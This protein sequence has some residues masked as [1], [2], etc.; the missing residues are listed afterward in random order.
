M[1]GSKDSLIFNYNLL[2]RYGYVLLN[3]SVCILLFGLLFSYLDGFYGMIEIILLVS[4]LVFF[5]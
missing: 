1:R 5:L 3:G 4:S 2:F